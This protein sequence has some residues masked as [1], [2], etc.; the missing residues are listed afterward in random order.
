MSI[1][2]ARWWSADQTWKVEWRAGPDPHEVAAMLW[3]AAADPEHPASRALRA[4]TS[5]D[6]SNGSP[7]YAYLGCW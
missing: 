7:H 4:M 3:Q 5:L 6:R 1:G 2:Q